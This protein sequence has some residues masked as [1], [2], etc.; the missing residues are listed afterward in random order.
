MIPSV[1][2]A[3]SAVLPGVTAS[4]L[5]G[6]PA[7]ASTR[8]MAP[9]MAAATMTAPGTGTVT[10]GASTNAT[11]SGTMMKRRPVVHKYH[12]FRKISPK[13]QTTMT[14]M[15]AAVTSKSH[16]ATSQVLKSLLESPGSGSGSVSGGALVNPQGSANSRGVPS[17][18]TQQ[19]PVPIRESR[20][21]GI[22]PGVSPSTQSMSPG[23]GTAG[24]VTR[25]SQA[26]AHQSRGTWQLGGRAIVIGASITTPASTSSAHYFPSPPTSSSD[27]S[28][29]GSTTAK[30][31]ESEAD[32]VPQ[33]VLHVS[34]T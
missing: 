10:S 23:G 19:V 24:S 6:R 11:T 20:N 1:N 9:T 31:V 14:M 12:T 2:A 7:I 17:L 25:F 18:P 3:S 33:P 13:N 5:T 26:P 30:K 29:G 8:S 32:V 4:L 22:L 34:F 15:S 28:S 21:A 27:V 16:V